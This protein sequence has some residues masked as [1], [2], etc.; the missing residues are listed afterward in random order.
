MSEEQN[1]IRYGDYVSHASVKYQTI[2]YN[3]LTPK[4]VLD[5]DGAETPY[6][7]PRLKLRS[8]DVYR[9]LYPYVNVR[10]TDQLNAVAPLAIY[11]VL[12]QLLILQVGIKDPWIIFGGLVSVVV[13]L[14]F[15]MEGLKLG[16]MPFGEIIGDKLPKKSSLPVVLIVAFMMGVGVTFAE[17]A[18]GALQIAGQTV[19]PVASPYLYAM[20]N[21]WSH[22]LVL[23]VGAG[24]GLA[25][26]LGSLRFI[27]G[28]SLKPF[29][30]MLLTPI[31]CLTAYAMSDPDLER[32]LGLA[33]DCGAV[34][35]GPVTVPL[36]LSLGIGI[37]SAAGKGDT[38]LS[39]FGIV[40]MAS[41]FPVMGVIILT[42]ILSQV[43]TPDEIIAIAA[44]A[45]GAATTT[46]WQDSTPFLE[47]ILSVRA[48]APM[49][50]FLFLVLTVV[51]REKLS[52]PAIILYGIT[53]ALIG[54]CVFNIGLTYGL[55]KLGD[56]SGSI[57]PA[58]FTVLSG[59][60]GSPLFGYFF[61]L[62][63]ALGFAAVLGFGATI[64]EPA[65]S[66]MGMT[67][68]NLTNGAYK[69]KFLIYAVSFGVAIG[70]AVGVCRITF[71]ISLGYFLIPGYLLAVILT[72]LSSEEFV[73]IAWDSAGVTTG[74]VTVPLVL[75]MGLGFGG[76]VNS[77]DGFGILAMASIGPILTVLSTGL[78]IQWQIK[79]SHKERE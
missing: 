66:A 3:E 23:S 72:Y 54:M 18:I 21:L 11:L 2:S 63:V 70:V 25:A 9:L 17:P 38:T 53:L 12:F 40:T 68:E 78:Y 1:T 71:G 56:Q 79:S 14:M 36:V 73:N 42:L 49:M 50:I 43:M 4:P 57:V 7:P 61:G 30:Y 59:I 34:T 46:T 52:N 47:I 16:L 44:A 39:G 8:L 26:A 6:T 35:T 74:P 22:W 62:I 19:D 28:W 75:A 55:S 29:I 58:A 45:E 20:L 41:L 64:A 13:G 65:L 69:K 27:Y 24:V 67:V 33:W 76:A 10:F 37:A 51:L 31:L 5:A 15:F 77:E 32:V 48:I 60:K